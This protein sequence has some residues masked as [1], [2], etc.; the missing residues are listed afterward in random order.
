M[1]QES[2]SELLRAEELAPLSL[3]AISRDFNGKIGDFQN[4]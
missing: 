3:L 1:E 2:D 4:R